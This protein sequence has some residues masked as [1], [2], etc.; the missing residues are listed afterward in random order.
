MEQAK[1]K[2]VGL[3]VYVAQTGKSLNL[4]TAEEVR[5]HFAWKGA[6]D[7]RMWG[8][9]RGRACY[10]LV[11]IP[12]IDSETEDLK[13]VF[14]IENKKPTL[15]QL[16]SYF[17]KEDQQL[18]TILGNSISFSLIIS[19][20]I[21]RL[22]KLERLVGDIRVLYDLDEA[23]FFILTGLTHRDGLQY[24]RAMIFLVD[25]AAPTKLV[26]RFAIGQI[27]PAQW[28]AEMDR[29]KDE[30]LLDL[31][32]LLKEFR[33]DK[34][35]YLRNPM[36]DRW[37]GCE[38]DIGAGDT[39]VIARHAATLGHGATLEPST[40]KYLQRRPPRGGHALRV[41]SGRL[42]AH[43]DHVREEVE[44]DHLRGQPLHGEPR[45]PV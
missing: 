29:R 34:Q 41:R 40:S 3:T 19:E 39:N 5:N 15:F 32:M 11:A 18:L 12:L 13:G 35:K 45:E 31:D 37:K 10:S 22:R 2:G 27:E 36:M 30:G 21:E 20:R 28:Q 26:C 16:Q 14:K 23:L 8:K 44:G 38:V 9:P 33:A 42:R 43:P 17:T 1:Y 6:N 24:N 7:E 4:T 25:E